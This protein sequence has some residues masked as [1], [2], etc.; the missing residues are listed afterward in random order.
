MLDPDL[1]QAEADLIARLRRTPGDVDARMQLFRVSVLLGNLDRA[2][3]Q[4]DA[5]VRL[6]PDLL[7]TVAVYRRAVLCERQRRRVFDGQQSPRLLGEPPQWVALL[8]QALAS[9]PAAAGVPLIR[10][11][12]D[13]APAVGGTLDGLRF[14]WIGDADAR[15]GP[16]LEAFVAGQYYWV[17]LQRV[18]RLSLQPPGD[19][20]DLAWYPGTL[21]LVSGDSQP[22]F[23]PARYPGTEQSG[24]PPLLPARAT[25]WQRLDDGLDIGPGQRVFC[26]DLGDHPLLDCR[27]LVLDAVVPQVAPVVAP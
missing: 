23:V 15:L 11:A 20:L 5:C 21:T 9:R 18:S 3:N 17:P 13:Q 12:L 26:T 1:K 4:L 25:D 27:E 24:D 10:A 14:E 19:A 6:A 7:E 16:V 8:A 2:D 22:V